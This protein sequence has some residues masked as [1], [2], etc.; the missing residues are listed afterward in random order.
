MSSCRSPSP[1]DVRQWI[2]ERGAFELHER[3][4]RCLADSADVIEGEASQPI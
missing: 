3:G 4:V 2:D 1:T